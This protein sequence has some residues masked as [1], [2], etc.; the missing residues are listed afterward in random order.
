M[1]QIAGIPYARAT[2]DKEG[3][4]TGEPDVPGGATEL[5]VV[6]HGW[7]ND[8]DEAEALYRALVTKLKEVN[9]D[10]PAGLAIV[11]VF[12][13]SKRFDLAP[14]GSPL[15]AEDAVRAAAAGGARGAARQEVAAAFARFDNVFDDAAGQRAAAA[16]RALLPRLDD[17]T[18][19]GEFVTLLRGLLPD[20]DTSSR[21][22]GSK[23]FFGAD[24]AA[25]FRNASQAASDTGET[26]AAQAG[27]DG[28]GAGLGDVFDGIG[29]AVTSLLN[30]TTYYAM[31]TRAG[32][33]GERGL[34]P[35]LDELAG[36]DAV[37]RIHLVGH[38]FGARLVTAAALASTTAKLHSM[39]LL[40]AAFSHN[41]FAKRG[42]FRAVVDKARLRG[43][44]LITH[45]ANDAA[46]GKAYAIASRLSG[47][48]AKSLG[49][50]DDP[51][52]GL[53]RNGA[54]NMGA[55]ELA[56]ETDRLLA[57]GKAYLLQAGLLHNLESSPFI[58]SHGDVAVGE[59]A[60]A[61]GRAI[62]A[63]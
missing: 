27:G 4:R 52:G 38:S 13:P 48:D 50:P 2:F 30:I 47:D 9:P 3:R 16:L 21:L 15:P 63:T 39:S 10:L 22:D 53:G 55:G 44:I 20:A 29:N 33:V 26:G 60:W 19:Q 43:P 14:D 18:A 61:I 37:R 8:A 42:Y 12:W 7:N 45:T 5:L 24:P 56:Q 17:E 49:G 62:A 23:V 25:V 32:V 59:V 41:G 35:L 54:R 58:R 57:V 51:F 31:K 34:A 1:S 36:R 40:Q 46:V 11:G 28:A 6:S